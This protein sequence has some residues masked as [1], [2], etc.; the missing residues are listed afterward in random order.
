[1]V[2]DGESQVICSDAVRAGGAEAELWKSVL[3]FQSRE[4]I[5]VLWQEVYG[6]TQSEIVIE[7]L[8]LLESVL[9]K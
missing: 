8:Y 6:N 5:G 3:R 1:M 2:S 4:W 7:S 9:D